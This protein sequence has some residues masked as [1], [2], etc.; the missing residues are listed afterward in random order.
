MSKQTFFLIDGTVLTG[1]AVGASTDSVEIIDEDGSLWALRLSNV[2]R[3]FLGKR[4][5]GDE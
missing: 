5:G 2:V 3:I 1:E 4:K